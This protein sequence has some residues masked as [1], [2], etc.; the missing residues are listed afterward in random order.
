MLEIKPVLLAFPKC[1]LRLSVELLFLW[2]LHWLCRVVSPDPR[3]FSILGCA[4]PGY[5]LVW[6][7]RSVWIV[8]LCP[9]LLL[10]LGWQE[11][12]SMMCWQR[13]PS[14]VSRCLSQEREAPVPLLP[15]LFSLL[16]AST[17]PHPVDVCSA[18][19][20][21]TRI[22]GVTGI[23]EAL[24]IC[25]TVGPVFNC[26]QPLDSAKAVGFTLNSKAFWGRAT[27][28]SRAE[29]LAFSRLEPPLSSVSD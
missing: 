12:K 27:H 28:F 9:C 17:G 4:V 16:I 19:S 18:V 3:C 5:L 21:E 14:D 29:A 13:S 11:H 8:L 23:R 26:P 25:D 20:S 22:Q 7:V 10:P 24:N 15:A 2:H 6:S 1:T